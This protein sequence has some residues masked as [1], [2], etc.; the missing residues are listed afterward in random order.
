MPGDGDSSHSAFTQSFVVFLVVANYWVIS[1]AMV[2][3]NRYLLGSADFPLEAPVFI[4]WLQC[5]VAIFSCGILGWIKSLGIHPFFDR[6]H[7][8][9]FDIEIMKKVL[10]LSIAFAGMI[11]FNNLCLKLVGVAFYNVGRSLTTVF[12]VLLTYL[13]LGQRVSA[14]TILMCAVIVFG[15]ML[16]VDQEEDSKELSDNT[17]SSF[18]ILGVVFGVLASLCV[19][20]NAVLTQTLVT[21]IKDSWLLT[22]YNN[23]NAVFILLPVIAMLGETE[24]ITQ[25]WS[26]ISTPYFWTLNFIAGFFGLAIGLATMLQIQH[27]SSLTHNVSGTAKSSAQTVFAI[28]LTSETKTFLW[29]LS[30]AMV[31]GGSFGY[32]WVKHEEMQKKSSS[33]Q[34][35]LTQK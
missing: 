23:L 30:N 3:L 4:T 26:L 18:S 10:P 28:M 27:T 24:Q 7:P 2:F 22:Y 1:I 8:F 19:A 35:P 14:K 25:H 17:V 9:Q 32:A 20:V 15:F 6:F 21:D 12:N 11:T 34:L 31:L 16:G 29:W 33:P 5:V 13:I